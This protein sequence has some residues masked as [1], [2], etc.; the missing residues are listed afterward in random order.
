MICINCEHDNITGTYCSKCGEKLSTELNT[1][2]IPSGNST[3]K[4]K[5]SSVHSSDTVDVKFSSATDHEWETRKK[6]AKNAVLGFSFVVAVITLLGSFLFPIINNQSFNDPFV[7]TQVLIMCGFGVFFLVASIVFLKKESLASA[8]VLLVLFVFY[9]VER[10]TMMALYTGNSFPFMHA[11]WALI[12]ISATT[13][14]VK[15]LVLGRTPP[16]LRPPK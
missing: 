6:G 10:I 13:S 3:V 11:V 12:A 5:H 8:I 9:I 7:L 16:S 1:Q 15:Y 14:L 4:D 2:K